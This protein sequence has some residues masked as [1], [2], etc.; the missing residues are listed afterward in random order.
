MMLLRDNACTDF[1]GAIIARRAVRDKRVWFAW[2]AGVVTDSESWGEV[3]RTHRIAESATERPK[4]D[5]AQCGGDE[6]VS[7]DP[8]YPAPK[9][10][11]GLNERKDLVMEGNGR[12]RQVSE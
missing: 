4:R 2:M 6:K 3:E 9:E 12:L 10:I 7:V 8:A 11:A 1:L 5:P